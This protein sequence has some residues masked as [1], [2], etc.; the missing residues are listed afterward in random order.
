MGAR[1]RKHDGGTL[2]LSQACY[3][4]V[5]GYPGKVA[6]VAYTLGMNAGTLA[7]KLNANVESHKLNADEAVAI[8]CV[9]RDERILNAVCF[10]M[11]AVWHWL[12]EV[13]EVPGDLDVLNQG[14]CVLD[15]SNQSIQE[16]ISALQD[17][18]V[19]QQEARRVN[20]AV[21][22]AQRQLTVLRR[23]SERFMD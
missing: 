19:D 15:A 3:H 9:T 12:D 18:R 13:K 23:L 4:A 22:E 17:G 7:N 5:Y 14:A 8:G 11:D 20:A 2:S 1:P 21:L 16:L 10:E 6:A